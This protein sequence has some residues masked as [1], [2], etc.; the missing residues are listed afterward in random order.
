M[1]NINKVILLTLIATPLAVPQIAQAQSLPKN[2]DQKLTGERL[3]VADLATSSSPLQ[4]PQSPK[5]GTPLKFV[6]TSVK[7]EKGQNRSG[8]KKKQAASLQAT[9]QLREVIPPTPATQESGHITIQ[10]S[11]KNYA[12][13]ED[14]LKEAKDGAVLEVHGKVEL[15]ND[16]PINKSITLKAGSQGAMLSTDKVH[17]TGT[18]SKSAEALSLQVDSGKTLTLGD[19]TTSELLLDEVHV[20]VTKG[21]L[22][23]QD[24]AR[25]N[26]NLSCDSNKFPKVN[27]SIVGISGKE[28]S[29]EFKG[30]VVENPATG[31]TAAFKND[32]IV[33]IQDKAQ[34]SEISGGTY[35]GTRV[36]FNVSDENTKITKI[37]GGT[38][39][40][41]DWT[42]VSSPCFKIENKARVDSISGGT[43][44]SYH[45]GAVQLESGA[46]IGEISAGTFTSLYPKAHATMYNG[47]IPYCSGLVLYG[48]NGSSPVVVDKIT[49][50]TFTGTN[51]ILSVGNE[52]K[53]MA[54]IQSITGGNFSSIDGETGNAGLYF[55]QNS[56]VGEISGNVVATGRNVGIWN[57]GTIKKIS[58]GTYTGQNFDGLKNVDYSQMK[59]RPHF[60]GHIEEITGGSFKGK[61]HGLMN[62]GVVD[63]ISGGIFD[64]ETNAIACSSKTK[65]GQLSTIK[66]GAFYAKK[67]TAI[68]LVSPLI[69]EPDLGKQNEAIGVGRYYASAGKAIFNDESKVTYPSYTNKG[70][71]EPYKMSDASDGQKDV[72]SYPDTAFRYLKGPNLAVTFMNDGQTYATVQVEIG[73]SINSDSLADQK[74]PANASKDGYLFK[75]WNTQADGKG[76]T[77]DGSTAVQGNM[78]VYAIYDL[79]QSVLNAS[80]VLKVTDKTITEGESL[81]LTSLVTTASDAEDGDLKA[82]VQIKDGG[83]D[84]TTV[85]TYKITFTLTDKQGAK[86]TKTATVTVTAKPKPKPQPQPVP[87]PQPGLEPQPMPQPQPQPETQLQP[88]LEPQSQPQPTPQLQ[89]DARP[90]TEGTTSFKA[91]SLPHTL[92]GEVPMSLGPLLLIS[93]LCVFSLKKKKR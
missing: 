43:F 83:F 84:S 69:L 48:R 45:F 37:T 50:G 46:S 62:A 88:E 22:V 79:Q 19:G 78:T 89:Q 66:G 30:G 9:A 49:G 8:D 76:T 58:G 4:A 40:Q 34:I 53:L 32:T 86:V 77:F 39:E 72:A 26:S 67:G 5:K 31:D 55:T 13:L 3:I 1:E 41:S 90:S 23:L 44:T 28:S 24:G 65:K 73:K 33:T 56:E 71:K 27:N 38:F 93:G 20:Y 87:T 70:A 7:N 59:E 91:K 35:K 85:G 17:R 12:T 11:E 80:P 47:A 60:K 75:E 68:V 52:P 36:V 54:K 2:V 29:A 81:D 82:K 10:G 64:G 16:V 63:T 57:A 25:I 14:A 74:M 6:L 42:G 92:M 51:G 15:H 18:A 21:K 61:E